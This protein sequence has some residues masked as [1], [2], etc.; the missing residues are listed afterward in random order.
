[1]SSRRLAASLGFAAAV[2]L[3]LAAGLARTQSQPTDAPR[4]AVFSAGLIGSKHDFTDAG[5]L[6]RDLCLPCH[7]PHLS[8]IP[9]GPTSRP[10]RPVPFVRLD[11]A[12]LSE[13]SLICLGCHDGVAAPGVL[14]GPHAMT[15]TQR[16][17]AG[18]P[19]GGARLTSHPVGT[20]YPVGNPRYHSR[21]AVESAGRIKL[22]DGRIQCVSCH[23]PHNA[24]RHRG[25]LVESNERSRLCLACHRI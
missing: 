17:S 9:N 10:A 22:P 8:P 5:R 6:P 11:D 24:G 25:M 15:W 12:V 14:V 23:D 19:P 2:T 13:S 7:T 16:D 3:S 18:L 1:M 20:R 21:A 4:P